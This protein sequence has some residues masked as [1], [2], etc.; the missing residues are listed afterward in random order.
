MPRAQMA[1]GRHVRPHFRAGNLQLK[2]A[3]AIVKKLMRLAKLVSGISFGS[4]GEKNELCEDQTS[5]QL[6]L[7]EMMK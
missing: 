4:F 6:L 1:A 7:S 3:S 2:D 5:Q